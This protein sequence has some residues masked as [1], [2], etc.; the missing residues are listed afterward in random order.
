MQLWTTV[1]AGVLLGLVQGCGGTSTE[2]AADNAGNGGAGGSGG[3]GGSSGSGGSNTSGTGGTGGGVAIDEAPLVVAVALCDKIYECCD[4]EELMNI[5]V[6]G[7]GKSQCQFGVAVFLQ[8][9]VD[10]VKE[11]IADGR[12]EYDPTALTRCL[13]DYGERSCDALR[14][15]ESFECEGLLVPQQLEGEACGV[16]TEC[17][18]GYC[19]GGSDASAPV[20]KCVPIRQNGEGCSANAECASGSCGTEGVCEDA[21]VLVLCGG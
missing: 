3:S 11:A 18:D 7:A 9:Q 21:P 12:V 19:A 17:I 10:A 2:R 4:A 5:Q 15:I 13:D 16:S 6:I 1:I 14:R 8:L 20:G